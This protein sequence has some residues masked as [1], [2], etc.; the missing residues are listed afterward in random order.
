[1]TLVDSF[2]LNLEAL[3]DLDPDLVILSFDPGEAVAALDAVEI[4][5]LL[6]G[7]PLDLDGVYDQIEALGI[8]TGHEAKRPASR[9]RWRPRSRRRSPRSVAAGAAASPTTTRPTR[10]A[11][12]RRTRSRSSARSMPCS[13]WRT[14]PTGPPT[15]SAP[16]FRSSPPST[17]SPPTRAIIFL[18]GGFEDAATVAA[19]DGW[20]TMT[21]VAEGQVVVL[22]YDMAS[23]WGPRVPELL[24]D[25]AA[26]LLAYLQES[27]G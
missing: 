8:A 7:T 6:F 18:G 24:D 16:G 27:A 11:S 21:A 19:R 17:S 9:P 10:S 22:D 25:I 15:T 4:P 13:A 2:N 20:D 26:G 23:R 1:M 5:T 12:T 14:S 3:I